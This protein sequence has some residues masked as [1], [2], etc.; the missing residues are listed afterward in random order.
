M[1]DSQAKRL[2][3]AIRT[4]KGAALTRSD[5]DLINAALADPFDQADMPRP[6]P[7][8]PRGALRASPACIALIHS[9]ETLELRSYRDPGSRDGL[10]ITNGWGTTREEDGGRISLGTVWTREKADR[11]FARDLR[12]FED[13]V[14]TLLAGAPTTQYQFDALVSFAYNVGLDMNKNGKA[15]GLGESTLLRKHLRGDYAGAALE[16]PKWNKN[17]GVVLKGLV[18]RRA[19][20]QAMYRGEA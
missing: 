12:M 5:V 4:V 7:Q 18:R 19:A 8:T 1:D 9:F 14:N 11:L 13:G 2:F 17:D 16:F 15:E 10:P 6:A 20:E 3:D